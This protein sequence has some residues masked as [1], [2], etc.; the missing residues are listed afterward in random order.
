MQFP[1][2]SPVLE[3][4]WDEIKVPGMMMDHRHVRLSLPFLPICALVSKS[5]IPLL[6]DTST[7]HH[8]H[9]EGCWFA[10]LIC[11]L[12]VFCIFSWEIRNKVSRVLVPLYQHQHHLRNLT[13]RDGADLKCEL[14]S[15]N[16]DSSH[17][18]LHFFLT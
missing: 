10:K 8:G 16:W 2:V 14:T 6:C 11:F 18:S 13:L 1:T 7:T 15:N 4:N 12:P 5:N 9:P 3:R 17:K